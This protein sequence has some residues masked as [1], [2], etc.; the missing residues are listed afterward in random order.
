LSRLSEDFAT[1]VKTLDKRIKSLETDK[2]NQ[3]AQQQ[4]IFEQ[5]RKE[6]N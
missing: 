1:D 6:I 2:S 4:E 3:T 5:F